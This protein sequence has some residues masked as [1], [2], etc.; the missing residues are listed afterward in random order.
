MCAARVV[1]VRKRG[2]QDTQACLCGWF[3][4]TEWEVVFCIHGGKTKDVASFRMVGAL[5]ALVM[6]GVEKFFQFFA[7]LV[8]RNPGRRVKAALLLSAPVCRLRLSEGS[9]DC[10]AWGECPTQLKGLQMAAL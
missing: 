2:G 8:A 4:L 9:V 7:C 5:E 3:F 1:V 10:W 6:D